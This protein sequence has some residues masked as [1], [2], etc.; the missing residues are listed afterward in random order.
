M[1]FL[2]YAHLA[3]KSQLLDFAWILFSK[4]QY[5]MQPGCTTTVSNTLRMFLPLSNLVSKMQTVCLSHGSYSSYS[6]LENQ[7]TLLSV[8][9]TLTMR[10]ILILLDRENPNLI[11]TTALP[12]YRQPQPLHQTGLQTTLTSGMTCSRHR[13]L[14]SE[15]Q[16]L[17]DQLWFRG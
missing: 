4:I 9:Q 10:S 12:H 15:L 5:L 1:I 16:I 6:K 14:G 2:D 17:P 11:F 8:T 7:L 3:G 13:P